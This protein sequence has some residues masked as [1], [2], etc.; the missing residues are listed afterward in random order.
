MIWG[1]ADVIIIGVKHSINIMYWIIP[2]SPCNLP[3]SVEKLAST[4]PVPDAKNIEDHCT[5]KSQ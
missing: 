2:K 1:G 5:V 4:K 3:P